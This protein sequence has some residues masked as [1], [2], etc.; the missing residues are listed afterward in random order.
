MEQENTFKNIPESSDAEMS[1]DTSDNTL[2]FNNARIETR[3]G[4]S[5]G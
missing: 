5:G 4:K 2:L 3:D 1:V